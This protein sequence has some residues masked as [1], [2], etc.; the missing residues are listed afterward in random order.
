MRPPESFISQPIRSLQTMLRVIAQEDTK[1]PNV[2]PD[3]IYGTQTMNAVA[4]FQRNH[5]LPPTGVTD[6]R[7]W[8][9]VVAVYEPALIRVG[10][11]QPLE[12]ILHP[13]QVIRRGDREPNVYIVQAVLTVL[14]QVYSSITPPSQTGVLDE[15]T[16][17]ALAAFQELTGLP[18]TGELDKVTWKQLALHYP[19][20]ANKSMPQTENPYP[21]S[22]IL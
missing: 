9:S 8:E 4:A 16:A 15:A 2:I 19:L 10:P 14:A 13:G 3:G 12:I 5:G 1:Q 7:T 17:I 18:Q 6:Q 11:A 21:Y 22:N 20:A